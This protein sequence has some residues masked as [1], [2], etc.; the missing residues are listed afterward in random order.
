MGALLGQVCARWL[1]E[2]PGWEVACKV[3]GLNWA[4][5]LEAARRRKIPEEGWES[6]GGCLVVEADYWEGCRWEMGDC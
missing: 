6:V 5:L 4:K 2:E 3:E 1:E